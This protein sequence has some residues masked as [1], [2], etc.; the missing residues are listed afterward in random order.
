MATVLVATVI[1]LIL[2]VLGSRSNHSHCGQRTAMMMMNPQSIFSRPSRALTVTRATN[3]DGR[4]AQVAQKLLSLEGELAFI[5]QPGRIPPRAAVVAGLRKEISALRS[6]LTSPGS[7]PSLDLT[8]PKAP[9]P[10]ATTPTTPTTPASASVSASVPSAGSKAA[11]REVKNASGARNALLAIEK[12]L[13]SQADA[14]P[15]SEKAKAALAMVEGK[16]SSMREASKNLTEFESLQVENALLRTQLEVV[17]ERKRH[18]SAL[19]LALKRGLV[20][21]A[22]KTEASRESTKKKK[23]EVV[24]VV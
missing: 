6:E 11:G 9:T 4:Q 12:K 14:T 3:M 20:G 22:K 19:T 13:G 23:E 21:N 5:T 18:L 8:M 17:M 24:Y 10:Q 2:S 7:V 16:V 1:F 15:L